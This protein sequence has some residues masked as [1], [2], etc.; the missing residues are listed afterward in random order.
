MHSERLN[1]IV[2]GRLEVVS[3]AHGPECPFSDIEHL[4]QAE[5]RPR[6][7]QGSS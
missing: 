5:N 1:A 2:V 4:S 6:A 7:C 3:G